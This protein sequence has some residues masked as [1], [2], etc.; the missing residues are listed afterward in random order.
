MP[1]LDALH[2]HHKVVAVV[3]SPDALVGRKRTLTPSP[4]AVLASELNIPLLKPA[5]VKNEP[6]FLD[7]LAALQADVFIVVSYG[8]ILPNNLINLPP[9]KTLNVHFSHLPFYRGASPIQETLRNGDTMTATSIF[10]LDSELDHGPIIAQ[11]DTI[12]EADDNFV[13]L[14]QRMAHQSA[15]LLLNILPEYATGKITPQEQDHTRAS[16]TK[17]IEKGDGRIVWTDTST[18]IY[19]QFRAFYPWPGLW[20]TWNDK[21]LKILDCLPQSDRSRQAET[22]PAGTVLPNGTVVCGNGTFL[23]IRHLQLEGK[24]PTPLPNFINGYSN[25]PGSLLQ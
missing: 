8:K 23:Q 5:R 12:I 17:I 19:N 4:V 3:T 14:S 22:E 25:F 10:I 13:T 2:D 21:T 18:N 15:K 16:T 11:E 1:V 9:L 24:T 20:T 7:A 6:E